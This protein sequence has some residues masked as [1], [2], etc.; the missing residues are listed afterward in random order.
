MVGAG[1]VLLPRALTSAL[2]SP[3]PPQHLHFD[4]VAAGG[5][6][7]YLTFPFTVPASPEVNRIDVKVT[8]DVNNSTLAKL[9]AGLFDERGAHYQSPGFRGVYGE[10]RNEFF[11]SA[12]DA[13][14][15]FIPGTIRPGTWT[16]IVPVFL[17]VV[18]TPVHVDITLSF[19][20]QGP[21]FVPGPAQ[22][23]VVRPGAAWYKG[24]LHSH[25][26]ESS[27]AWGSHRAQRPVDWAVNARKYGL[28]FI[29]MTDHNVIGQNYHLA[30]DA[31][32]SGTL[33]IAGEEM[34]NWF[35]GHA[36]VT[37][38]EVGEWLDWRQTP[39]G[40]PLPSGGVRINEFMKVAK[41]MGAYV[42]AAHPY[43]ANLSWQFF[44]DMDADPSGGADPI[45]LEVW[46]GD[47]Q[48]DDD[49][50][51]VQWDTYLRQGRRIWANGGSDIHGF[52]PGRER[53]GTPTNHVYA[54]NLSKAAIVEALKQGRNFISRLPDGG[55]VYLSATGAS[56]QHQVVGGTIY[57]EAT[58]VAHVEMLVRRGAG[59][60]LAFIHSNL[61]DAHPAVPVTVPV[62][63][64]EQVVKM[65]VPIG[66]A[67]GYVRAELHGTMYLPP[68]NPLGGHLDMESFTN[69]LF[70]VNGP[71]PAGTEPFYAPAPVTG[72]GSGRP[73]SGLPNT[74][75]DVVSPV[76]GAGAMVS[77]AGS[78]VAARRRRR[79]AVEEMTLYEVNFRALD[80]NSLRGRRVR[81]AGQVTAVDSDGRAV[82]TRWMQNCCP[83]GDAPVSLTLDGADAATVGQWIEVEGCWVT[84]TG[85]R[86]QLATR[87]RCTAV[88]V[89]DAAPPCRED[90]VH[91]E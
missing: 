56:N 75:V 23:G 6:L 38:I 72:P 19:G 66:R 3:L 70:L 15:S 24:D 31:G 20:P 1:A 2:A 8:H 28:D 25:T 29:A 83:T 57:G 54:D 35:H 91:T 30:R 84:G 81:L 36:T 42:A 17:V 33:L 13:S 44:G 48:P 26:P 49:A 77:L 14:Q 76:L 11:V 16:V 45:G 18:P 9:G 88:R 53:F 7:Q 22:L 27:D 78:T 55:E 61:G 12:S 68:G 43:G 46:T 40:L 63:T 32:T 4:G 79:R 87:V 85:G 47:F 37:G 86:G 59:M 60:K 10:E 69:P 80:G 58:D 41:G 62:T 73:G 64:D 39:L 71:V 21:A 65:D 67:G 52:T 90:H 34:T 51:L 50:S 89:L 5:Y 74:S 82:L